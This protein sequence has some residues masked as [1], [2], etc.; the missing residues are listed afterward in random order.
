MY[1]DRVIS[2]RELIAKSTAGFVGRGWVRD[3]INDFLRA[4]GP[5]YFLILG[6]PGSGKTAFMADLVK[7]HAYPHHFIGRGGRSSL[8]FCRSGRRHPFAFC[9]S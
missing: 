1:I 7:R 9:R 6:E 8:S 3:A 2:Y 4:D 5:R